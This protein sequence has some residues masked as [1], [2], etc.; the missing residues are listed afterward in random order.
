MHNTHRC[1]LR[2]RESRQAPAVGDLHRRQ[3]AANPHLHA[4]CILQIVHASVLARLCPSEFTRLAT[5]CGTHGDSFCVREQDFTITPGEET[6]S[7]RPGACSYTVVQKARH[8]HKPLRGVLH[9]MLQELPV[10]VLAFLADIFA[11]NT[12]SNLGLRMDM[13]PS[14]N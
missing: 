2:C 8:S 12:S 4:S 14:A 13:R 1:P 9:R 3:G 5:R 7:T 10:S 11:I 6:C